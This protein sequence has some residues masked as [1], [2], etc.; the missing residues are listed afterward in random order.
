MLCLI[1]RSGA[2]RQTSGDHDVEAVV[3][4]R[5]PAPPSAGGRARGGP[6]ASARLGDAEH[7][8]AAFGALLAG[9]DLPDPL[10]GCDQDALALLQADEEA[11]GRVGLPA[12]SLIGRG[13]GGA[14]RRVQHGEH[15]LPHAPRRKPFEAELLTFPPGRHD[16][17]VDALGLVGQLL[18]K[19]IKGTTRKPDAKA[20]KDSWAR[21]VDR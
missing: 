21:L 11:P 1:A 17:Q 18:D 15:L 5:T 6:K 16:D 12:G 19:K 8:V 14:L 7:G 3:G 9:P 13:D 4:S 10:G 2:A 20:P